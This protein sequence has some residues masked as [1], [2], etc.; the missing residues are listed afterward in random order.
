MQV[1]SARAT[2]TTRQFLIIASAGKWSQ[3]DDELSIAIGWSVIV[4]AG[5]VLPASSAEVVLRAGL[6]V[7]RALTAMSS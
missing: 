4:D 6:L 1:V 2:I 5:V 3:D 7:L